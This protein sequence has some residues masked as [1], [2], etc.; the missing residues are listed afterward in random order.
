MN[1][2]GFVVCSMTCENDVSS[3]VYLPIGDRV[4]YSKMACTLE[5]VARS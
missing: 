3:T 4:N 5:G 1:Y 2:T